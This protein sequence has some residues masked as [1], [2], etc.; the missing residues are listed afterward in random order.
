MGL[1][2]IHTHTLHYVKT[3]A[4]TSSWPNP[5][6]LAAR[7][8]LAHPRAVFHPCM[9]VLRG[10]AAVV[11]AVLIGYGGARLLLGRGRGGGDHDRLLPLHRRAI[12][13]DRCSN[14]FSA[15]LRI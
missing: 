10:G 4:S 3:L 14:S 6:T 1:G 13:L 15:A 2:A 8:V 7:V 12:T 11:A 9:C 5:E